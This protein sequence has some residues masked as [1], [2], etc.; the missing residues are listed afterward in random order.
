MPR[1]NAAVSIGDLTRNRRGLVF[2]SLEERRLLDCGATAGFGYV[3]MRDGFAFLITGSDCQY[4]EGGLAEPD[5]ILISTNTSGSIAT[6]FYLEYVTESGSWSTLLGTVSAGNIS[7]EANRRG[8]DSDKFLGIYVKSLGGDDIVRADGGG[9]FGIRTGASLGP[10]QPSAFIGQHLIV[11]GGSGDDELWGSPGHDM[12][13]GGPGNDHL[14]GIGG[15]DS[16]FGSTGND[17]ILGN[18]GADYLRGDEGH[19]WIEGHGGNDTIRGGDGDDSISGQ[20]GDDALS[21]GAGHDDLRG[22]GGIDALLGGAGDD[23]L[24]GD[25]LDMNPRG[26]VGVDAWQA[27]DTTE[28]AIVI[29]NSDIEKIVTTGADPGEPTLENGHRFDRPGPF[30]SFGPFEFDD[31]V[32]SSFWLAELVIRAVAM[33]D[34]PRDSAFSDLEGSDLAQLDGGD[35]LEIADS[36]DN[37]ESQAVSAG[38]G[39]GN[40]QY[41]VDEQLAADVNHRDQQTDPLDD[42]RPADLSG[43]SRWATLRGRVRALAGLAKSRFLYG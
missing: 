15:N 21:G 35:R 23:S 32:E 13:R 26:G 24:L 29:Q 33:P 27:G 14:L 12:L 18:E 2:E 17:T 5:N 28:S 9:S 22:D 19:D 7:R 11:D 36:P 20:T 43:E 40:N 1:F 25:H 39:A 37:E 38:N 30:G 34:S 6:N 10:I 31:Q 41:R 8:V 3:D 16:L 4:D 42:N